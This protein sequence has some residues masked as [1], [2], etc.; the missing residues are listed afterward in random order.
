MRLARA[1]SPQLAFH[2]AVGGDLGGGDEQ[3]E[4][5]AGGGHGEEEQQEQRR[6]GEEGQS[7]L[8]VFDQIF[9]QAK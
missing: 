8:Q 5:Q 2:L 9:F 7:G 1:F 4:Q 6:G 3:E